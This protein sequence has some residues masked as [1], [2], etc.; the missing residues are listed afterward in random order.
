[1]NVNAS[2]T[3]QQMQIRKMDGSG[4]GQSQSAMKDIMQSLSSEDRTMLKE[5]ISSLS[6]ADRT[7][8]ISQMQQVDSTTMTS[9][10]YSQMLLDILNKDTKS[11]TTSSTAYDF[12]VYG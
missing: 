9:K 10:E 12:S 2:N 11:S 4:K 8:V 7:S 1:M 3:S 5:K 6:Q